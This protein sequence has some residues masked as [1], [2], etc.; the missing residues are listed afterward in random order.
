MGGGKAPSVSTVSATPPPLPPIEEAT[1]VEA[2]L[3][4]E[5]EKLKTK[6]LSQG[7]KSLQIPL[8]QISGGSGIGTI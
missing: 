4:P 7:A 5:A 6:A 2:K 3:T 1:M 8:G